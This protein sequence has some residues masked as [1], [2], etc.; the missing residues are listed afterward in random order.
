MAHPS[1]ALATI[2]FMSLLILAMATASLGCPCPYTCVN[3]I[4]WR[5][6]LKQV[7]G[8]GPDHNQEGFF[9]PPHANLFGQTVVQDW[10]IVDAPAP[11][12]KVHV[13]SDL[14]NVNWFVSLNIVF[15]G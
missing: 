10:T 11:D 1:H 13:M 5:L 3:E 14:A 4:N 9:V 6:Y 7:G 2:L 15:Q 12:A 8:T